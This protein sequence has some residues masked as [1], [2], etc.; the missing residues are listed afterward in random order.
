M[1]C[2][3]CGTQTDNENGVCSACAEKNETPVQETV[4]IKETAS[5][6]Q[7][8]AAPEQSAA[9][10]DAAPKNP[11][12]Q[13]N[14]E[15]IKKGV[16]NAAE[17]AADMAKEAAGAAK[18]A[19]GAAKAALNDKD[20]KNKVIIAAAAAV[21]VILLIILSAVFSKPAYQKPI[22]YFVKGL[23]TGKYSTFKKSMP[24]YVVRSLEDSYLDIESIFDSMADEMKDE[25][26]KNYKVSYKVKRKTKLDKDDLEDV[27]DLIDSLYDKNVKVTGG[28]ELKVELRLTAKGDTEKSKTD[29]NVYK[30]DGQWYMITSP[31]GF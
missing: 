29:I 19:A 7:Q 20:K 24:K 23:S 31:F 13:I 3:F 14:T 9:Q 21:G 28:Y 4:E 15:E 1:F 30:I 10:G 8:T 27:E 12:I 6:E 17:K 26:G 5:Q 22:D 11:Y 25:Y 2:K 16:A 18:E